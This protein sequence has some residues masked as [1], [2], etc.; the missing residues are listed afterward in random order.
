M[1]PCEPWITVIQCLPSPTL[2]W[3]RW[4][5]PIGINAPCCCW[6]RSSRRHRLGNFCTERYT[7]GNSLESSRRDVDHFCPSCPGITPG[8]KDHHY[9]SAWCNSRPPGP[10][11][12]PSGEFVPSDTP[13]G[14]P[15]NCAAILL[16]YRWTPLWYNTRSRG[17]P[18]WSPPWNLWDSADSPPGSTS[19]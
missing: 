17:P 9:S 2:P 7:A 4:R 11:L 18:C 8:L 19:P 14:I 10:P 12:L 13:L 6:Y 1:T 16:E 15:W 3:Y 5:S